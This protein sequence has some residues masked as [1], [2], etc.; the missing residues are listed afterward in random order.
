MQIQLVIKDGNLCA[1]N[2]YQVRLLALVT[3]LLIH[4]DA[5]SKSLIVRQIPLRSRQN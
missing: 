5:K 4:D 2:L 3:L 1:H